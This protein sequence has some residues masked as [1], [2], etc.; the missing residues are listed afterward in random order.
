MSQKEATAAQQINALNQA[1]VAAFVQKEDAQARIVEA[2]ASIKAIRNQLGGI[3]IGQNLQTEILKEQADAAQKAI[4]D[5]RKAE[6]AE[7]EKKK[8]A[9]DA[10]VA[11]VNGAIKDAVIRELRPHDADEYV[12]PA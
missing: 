10:V 9:S 3:K 12:R 8:A 1:L 7:L 5:K 4:D 2:E 6:Q 11:Q